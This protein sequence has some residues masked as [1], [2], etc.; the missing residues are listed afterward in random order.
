[1]KRIYIETNLHFDTTDH[2]TLLILQRVGGVKE[3]GMH[4]ITIE[5][6]EE[7]SRIHRDEQRA[8]Y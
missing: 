2:F 7:C 4:C 8:L 1:M 5:E 6:S 3:G